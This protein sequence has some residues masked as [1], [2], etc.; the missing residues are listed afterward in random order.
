MFQSLY[1]IILREQSILVTLV[2]HYFM[3]PEDD[4]IEGLKHVGDILNPFKSNYV[5]LNVW[6][7][8][9]LV[10]FNKYCYHIAR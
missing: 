9:Q 5:V 3:L 7:V 10:G 8:W 6:Q 2:L 1:G 4:P